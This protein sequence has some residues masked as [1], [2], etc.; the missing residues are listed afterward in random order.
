MVAVDWPRGTLERAK[1][2]L[3]YAKCSSENLVR[4]DG[5]VRGLCTTVS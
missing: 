5:E 3:L 1:E 2:T 4:A